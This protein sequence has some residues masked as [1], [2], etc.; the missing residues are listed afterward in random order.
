MCSWS[1]SFWESNTEE[2]WQQLKSNSV[3]ESIPLLNR[4]PSHELVNEQLV[5]FRGM[6]Q[7]MYDPEFYL[8]QY[9]VVSKT[10]ACSSVRSGN[11]RDSIALE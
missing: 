2:C 4:L 7:D 1:I 5:R 9:E 3:W 6:I 11:Y 10:D 8:S